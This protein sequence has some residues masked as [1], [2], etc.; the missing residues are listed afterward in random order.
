MRLLDAHAKLLALKQDVLQTNDAAACLQIPMLH[1]SQVLRRLSK[2]GLFV[3]LARGIWA[4]RATIDPL[5]LPEPL[6][7]PAPCYISFQSALYYHGMIS[8][9]PDTVYAATLARTRQYRT[10]IARI[11]IHHIQ[12][13]F[14]FGFEMMAQSKIKMATPEKALL[15]VFYLSSV[16]SFLFSALPELEIPRH[17]K[18]KE[19]FK[20]IEKITSPRIR[21]MVRNKLKL[22]T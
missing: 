21:T 17:F 22:I 11:S 4:C 18:S 7:A 10:P 1:A 3:P 15:D 16:R 8:Q 12:P 6:T 19:A 2:A 9:I 13:S 5:L 14:F 20:M